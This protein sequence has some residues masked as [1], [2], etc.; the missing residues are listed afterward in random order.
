VQPQ[1]LTL[2]AL[3]GLALASLPF[4]KQASG[5]GHF[6]VV[7]ECLARSWASLRVPWVSLRDSFAAAALVMFWVVSS[8]FC[9]SSG[10]WIWWCG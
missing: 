1:G 8:G 4:G 2:V 6:G 9:L 7:V 10:V 5:G 3:G